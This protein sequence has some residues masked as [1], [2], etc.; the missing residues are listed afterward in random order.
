[1]IVGGEEKSNKSIP[2]RLRAEQV[3]FQSIF[4][5]ME[6]VNIEVMFQMILALGIAPSLSYEPTD[7]I[8][9]HGSCMVQRE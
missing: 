5:A 4:V 7:A 6:R 8:P 1:M 3:F 2:V 9:D